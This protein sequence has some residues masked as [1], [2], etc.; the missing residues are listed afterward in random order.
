MR[1]V[2][3]ILLFIT[4]CSSLNPNYVGVVT[5]KSSSLLY[6]RQLE[7]KI[8]QRHYVNPSL[9]FTEWDSLQIGDKIIIDPNTLKLVYK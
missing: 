1:E 6:G 7:S 4:S 8:S 5:K 3:I 2:L 9:T